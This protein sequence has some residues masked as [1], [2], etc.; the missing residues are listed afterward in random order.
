MHSDVDSFILYN[1]EETQQTTSNNIISKP[2][3]IIVIAE[4]QTVQ[5]PEFSDKKMIKTPQTM[6]ILFPQ[7]VRIMNMK[8]YVTL[9]LMGQRIS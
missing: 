5:I 2:K 7:I 4:N 3:E 6:K 9:N 8:Y 1:V